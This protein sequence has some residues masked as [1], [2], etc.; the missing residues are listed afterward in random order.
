VRAEGAGGGE[1]LAQRGL[2]RDGFGAEG[3][4]DGVVLAE[5][6]FEF[7]G[8]GF[9]IEEITDAEAGA[10]G[11][12]TVGRSDTAFGGADLVF[13]FAEFAGFVDGAVP[14]H[15]EV[16]GVAE[17]E[18]RAD[19]D[20]LF[21]EAVD[22]GDEGDGVDDNAVGDDAGFARAEDAAGNQVQDVFFAAVN[23]GVSGVV[24]ALTADDE[25]GVI[26]KK[27]DDFAFAFVTPLGS[28]ENGICHNR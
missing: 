17:E 28:D 22:F 9:A 15:D 6:G 4:E 27:V 26:G 8:E 5:A 2:E 24:T 23:D 10:G 7:F 13:A 14:G 25:V 18:V 1:V 20:A 11:F 16:G 12:V 19:F 3:A 21:A